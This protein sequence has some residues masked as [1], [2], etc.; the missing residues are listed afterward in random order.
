MRD[1]VL[2][3]CSFEHR[4]WLRGMFIAAIAATLLTSCQK[5]DKESPLFESYVVNEVNAPDT[6]EVMASDTLRMEIH[7]TDNRELNQLRIAIGAVDTDVLGQWEE[8][9]VIS[10]SGMDMEFGSS[11]VIPDSIQGEWILKLLLADAAGNLADEQQTVLLISNALIPQ[12]Q[13]EAINGTDPG[14]LP[15]LFTAEQLQLE[16]AISD[17]NGLMRIV[18]SISTSD[19]TYVEEEWQ[20]EDQPLAWNLDQIEVLAPD[21]ALTMTFEIEAFD[22][23][24]LRNVR[25]Y[26]I[27]IIE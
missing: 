25:D 13:V 22:Q 16:G 4:W 1:Q 7:C 10:L 11:A 5:E 18:V 3:A 9:D 24:G 8:F 20:L 15:H 19:S 17:D 26:S 27:E 23:T 12:I 6:L 2:I 14:E 21:T